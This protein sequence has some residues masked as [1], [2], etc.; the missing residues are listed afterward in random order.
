MLARAEACAL[1]P[2]KAFMAHSCMHHPCQ[3][4]DMGTMQRGWSGVWLTLRLASLGGN[5]PR[6][7]HDGGSLVAVCSKCLVDTPW[8]KIWVKRIH[9][10]AMLNHDVIYAWC[11]GGRCPMLNCHEPAAGNLA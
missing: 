8:G 4:T 2:G 3:Q 9:Q 7:R 11:Q 5:C 1:S 6:S 10:L